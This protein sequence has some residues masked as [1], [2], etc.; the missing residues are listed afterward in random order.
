MIESFKFGEVIINGITYNQDLFIVKGK[1]TPSWW[2]KKG[3]LVDIP[4]MEDILGADPEI[5]IIGK[6]TN[7]RVKIS[8]SLRQHILEKGITLIEEK[9]PEAINSFN[10]LFTGGKNVAA[11][12]HI[13][14]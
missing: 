3:H 4:D 10:Q 12:F 9:T 13:T 1:V 5:L 2:R 14:C 6:G 8:D 11:G 7:G